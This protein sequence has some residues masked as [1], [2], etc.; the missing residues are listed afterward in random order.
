MRRKLALLVS[1]GLV[2]A[3]VGGVRATA[4]AQSPEEAAGEVGS[5]TLVPIQVTGPPQERL[6]LVVLSE[7]YQAAELEDFRA[8]LDRNHAVQWSVEP[9]RSYRH[10][11]NVYALEIVSGESGVRC[12]P[13]EEGGPDPNKVTPLRLWYAD[14]CDDPLARGTTYGPAPEGDPGGD[15]CSFVLGDP[16][17]DGDQQR[18]MYLEQYVAPELGIP[19]N[20]QNLQTL[21]IFNTF[22]YGG[23]GGRHATTSG[24][25]PQ[26]PLISLHE[27][28]HSLGNLQDEYP[29]SSRPMPGP[30]W[31]DPTVPG[32]C[33][34]PSSI[35]HTR[36]SS[37]QMTANQAKWWRWLGEESESGGI[38]RAADPN[39]Y[40]SG[41]Y[42]GSEIWRP[43]SHSMMRWI[44]FYLDQIGREHMTG[45]IT[46]QRDAG[47]MSL[48]H[49]PTDQPLGIDEVVWVEAMHPRYHELDVTWTVNGEPVADTHNGRNL[50]LGAIGVEPGD[51]VSVTVSDPTDFVRDP[52]QQTGPRM[53]QIREWTVGPDPTTP[54][55]PEVAITSNRPTAYPVGGEEVVYVETTHPSDRVLDVTWTLDGAEIDNPYNARNLDL[56]GL[57][58]DDGTHELT[59]TVTDP[60]DPGAG[61]DSV[62]WT[63]DNAMPTAPRE[64]SEPLTTVR[65]NA[66]HPVYFD[67]FD[68]LLEPADPAGEEGAYVVGELRLDGDGW[69]NYFGFP[70]QPF[71]TPFTFSHS[72]KVVKALTYGNLGT[73]GLSKAAF[74]QEYGPD[75]PNGPF[76]P[77]FG[78]H[79]VEHRA[80]DAAGNI[81]S[82]DEFHSTVLPG[83][84]PECTTTVTGR[85]LGGLTV[86]D[87][88]TCLDGATVLGGVKVRPGASLVASDSTI[89]G[90][91]RTDAAQA[92]QLFGSSVK[93]LTWIADT[94]A[95]VTIAGSEFAGLVRL[96]GNHQE[97]ANERFS[98]YAYEYGPILAGSTVAGALLCSGNSADVADFEATNRIR[99]HQSGQ[100][101]DL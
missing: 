13:D 96:V 3:M 5:A 84:S 98:Q 90:A 74:E 55:S 26:G 63:V 67:E 58:L 80:I 99:G 27:L 16:R 75:D 57:D 59:A 24:G 70:E 54:T 8:D 34:E 56:A 42:S 51:T 53:T 22:T 15:D 81:G 6:N 4:E 30:P 50:D 83:S 64:L 95:D 97:S 66:D 12:D 19:A 61:S 60:A 36:M 7:G 68:M 86:T 82:A 71:G 41:Q 85:R 91:L 49:T 29:Y 46:G 92:V 93:G 9:F 73:G 101:A 45:R 18:T 33:E 35:H 48:L 72:G 1:A 39:G 43:S 77:G 14:G 69:F 28:G 17:C 62:S 11:F 25:S 76:V 40:E 10:Y 79:T 32:D 47:R 88:V 100:C 37:E 89:I 21:A 38:I 78:T 44:G 23:I 65:G 87:G 94:T 52:A 20:A 31:C 2:A